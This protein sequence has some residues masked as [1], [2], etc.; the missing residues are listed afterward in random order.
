VYNK[1][2]RDWEIGTENRLELIQDH[3]DFDSSRFG[4]KSVNLELFQFRFW[5]LY[6]HVFKEIGAIS[7]LSKCNWFISKIGDYY[8]KWLSRNTT[9]DNWFRIAPNRKILILSIW[10]RNQVTNFKNRFC[11]NRFWYQKKFQF[12]IFWFQYWQFFQYR[13]CLV[14]SFVKPFRQNQ[15]KIS[16]TLAQT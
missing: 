13:P 3:F 8:K 12:D 14:Y 10:N 11:E 4:L 6:M 5:D 15:I 7:I 16:T 9:G 1:H 2:G